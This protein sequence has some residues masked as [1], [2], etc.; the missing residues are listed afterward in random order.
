MG[1]QVARQ[2]SPGED[3]WVSLA[4]NKMSSDENPVDIPLYWLVNKDPYIGLL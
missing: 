3:E 2:F 1:V 4:S